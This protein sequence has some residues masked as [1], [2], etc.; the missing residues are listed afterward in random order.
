MRSTTV[1]A[2]FY[3]AVALCSYEAK[4]TSA[5]A[6][7]TPDST[8]IATDARI[9]EYE[10]GAS[11]TDCKIHLSNNV[12]WVSS[13]IYQDIRDGFSIKKLVD[14]AIWQ[15]KSIEDRMST[16]EAI[17]TKELT[18]KMNAMLKQEPLVFKTSFANYRNTLS[19][20]FSTYENGNNYLFVF[21]FAAYID[22]ASG[23]VAILTTK[24]TNCPCLYR[25]K[26]TIGA[27]SA[28]DAELQRNPAILDS[29]LETGAALSQLIKLQ[30]ASTPE[31]VGPPVSIVEVQKGVPRWIA[32]GVCTSDKPNR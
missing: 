18:A 16:F 26:Y 22:P 11:R 23:A 24:K 2:I 30:I 19:I 20:M 14:E 25:F 28:I 13:G 5:I 17:A 29:P 9:T 12:F 1:A 21:V 7:W 15:S 3:F 31:Y 4:A 27:Q 8:F 6:V 10:N 32:R